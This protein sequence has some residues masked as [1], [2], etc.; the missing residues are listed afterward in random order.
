[1]LKVFAIVYFSIR[2]REDIKKSDV[3]CSA[4]LEMLC[5]NA[6]C[7]FKNLFLTLFR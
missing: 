5:S 3:R 4:H 7:G 2:I 1:M 6:A